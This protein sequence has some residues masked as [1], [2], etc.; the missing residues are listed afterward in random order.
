M[1]KVQCNTSTYSAFIGV[2]LSFL[3][4]LEYVP[5]SHHS[6]RN[7]ASNPCP[8]PA[9]S[10]TPASQVLQIIQR[11]ATTSS[12]S[13]DT[14]HH[15]PNTALEAFV[16]CL[17]S[18]HSFSALCCAPQHS[19]CLPCSR[20]CQRASGSNC[21]RGVCSWAVTLEASVK[22][23]WGWPRDL[24]SSLLCYTESLRGC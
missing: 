3:R 22:E 9:G 19:H 5:C 17:L 4:Y 11:S 6:T 18:K 8:C 13:S 7:S 2:L 15:C 20:Q 23:C 12:A 10:T 21:L 16:A 14:A 1:K 24:D